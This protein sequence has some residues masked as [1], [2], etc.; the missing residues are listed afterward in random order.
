MTRVFI[1]LWAVF[2]PASQ[3]LALD[4]FYTDEMAKE[5]V[6][7]YKDRK[8]VLPQRPTQGLPI[9]LRMEMI[10]L[11]KF[12]VDGVSL[13]EALRELQN[14]A[15]AS[16]PKNGGFVFLFVMDEVGSK[17][18]ITL[19]LKDVT[20]FQALNFVTELGGTGCSV[21]GQQIVIARGGNPYAWWRGLDIQNVPL[22]EELA[23]QWFPKAKENE[24][25]D[26]G[27]MWHAE[28]DLEKMGIPFNPDA[29]ADFV[30]S[31]NVLSTVHCG[32]ALHCIAMLVKESEDEI[33]IKAVMQ[34]PGL[35]P[36]GMA[37]KTFQLR[38]ADMGQM[39]NIMKHK[40]GL[41]HPDCCTTQD[42]LKGDGIIFPDKAAAW[43]DRTKQK[44]HVI[45]TSQQ[46]EA[47]RNALVLD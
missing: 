8:P 3:I 5:M 42:M 2:W 6:R 16:D 9:G 29:M 7:G 17:S 39:E 14:A 25:G 28:K 45:N 41:I 22:S 23:R 44:L 31:M 1:I 20:F 4:P 26:S 38:A 19:D 32:A 35:I 24:K 40:D 30:P 37:L 47:I 12:K 34:K 36:A 33:K 15:L 46:I 27:P 11:P 21:Y 43:F 10:R 13:P 18:S